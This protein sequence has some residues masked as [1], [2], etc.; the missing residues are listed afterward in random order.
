MSV[1]I[2]DGGDAYARN[3]LR[4]FR[5]ELTLPEAARTATLHCCAHAVYRLSINGQTIAHGPARAYPSRPEYDSHDLTGLLHAGDHVIQ[6]DVW[7]PGVWTHQ[8]LRL[9]A[10]FIAWGVVHGADGSVHDL[11]TP[12]A[13]QC[14]RESGYD[15]MAPRF[16]FTSG[17]VY[18]RDAQLADEPWH[19][20]SPLEVVPWQ[21]LQPRSIPLLREQIQAVARRLRAVR[22]RQD[23]CLFGLSTVFPE[24]GHLPQEHIRERRLRACARAWLYSPREQMVTAGVWWGEYACNGQWLATSD[25]ATLLRQRIELPLRAGWNEL[26]LSYGLLNETWHAAVAVPRAAGLHLAQAPETGAVSAWQCSAPTSAAAAEEAFAI[27]SGWHALPCRNDWGDAQQQLAWAWSQDKLELPQGLPLTIPAATPTGLLFDCGGTVSGRIRIVCSAPAGTVLEW[28][29]AEALADGRLALGRNPLVCAGERHRCRGGDEVIETMVPRGCRYL[30]LHVR[31]HDNNVVIHEIGLRSAVYPFAPAMPFTCSDPQWRRLHSMGWRACEI[32]AEDVWLDT[33]WRERVLHA[34]DVL[35]SMA[36]AL[37]CSGDGALAKRSAALFLESGWAD[38]PWLQSKVPVHPE[39]AP[40]FDYVFMPLP[41]IAWCL[42]W[43]PDPAFARRVYPRLR[44][45]MHDSLQLL[46]PDGVATA[47][48]DCFLEWGDPSPR[49]SST[50]Q[51][52]LAMAWES[53]A[54]L[55]EHA[56]AGSEAAAHRAHGVRVAAGLHQFWNEQVGAYCDGV[57][58]QGRQDD[59]FLNRG[60]AWALL[61]DACSDWQRQR[62]HHWY[63][64]LLRHPGH[65]RDGLPPGIGG[66]YGGFLACLALTR[67]GRAD[68]VEA[69]IHRCWGAMADSSGDTSWEYYHDRASRS[70]AWASAPTFLASHLLLGFDAAAWESVDPAELVLRPQAHSV[71]SASGTIPHPGGPV[72]VR[73]R[74]EPS[75]LHMRIRAPERLCIRVDPQGRLAQLPL[76]LTC[77]QYYFAP[78]DDAGCSR[79]RTPP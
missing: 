8:Q 66:P 10:A 49:R 23:E 28:G 44:H 19:A 24:L 12:G 17:P 9:P 65:G 4:S 51:G 30:Q 37:V 58:G 21:E 32:C 63:E 75:R 5:L 7:Q 77:E 36:S 34:G 3:S 2:G 31:E 15:A 70:H 22:L 38:S 72:E 53:L 64:D 52:I 6:V 50:L 41:I 20:V 29:S 56:G 59:R 26:Q 43:Q 1:W 68:L 48:S 61:V 54:Q 13:W 11:A 60:N 73:W 18:Q 14:R 16:S 40:L 71:T 35:V 74:L 78:A 79:H 27:S 39:H 42:R 25:D 57:D 46:G 47:P 33:P 69:W 62:L 45:L 67:D 55:A 76:D